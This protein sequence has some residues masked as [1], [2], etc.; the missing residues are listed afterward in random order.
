MNKELL[1]ARGAICLARDDAEAVDAATR[2]LMSAIAQRNGIAAGDCVFI[3]FSIT[4][5][6]RSRNPATSA[7]EAGWSVPL[8]CVREAEFEDSTPRVLRALVAF[9]A[10]PDAEAR[11]AYLDG[12]EKL[13]PDLSPQFPA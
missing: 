7:R 3:L 6:I 4:S 12:A 10:A 13:R 9:R 11:H 5:D 1:A 2:R 8:F